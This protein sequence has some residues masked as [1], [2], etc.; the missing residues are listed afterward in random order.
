VKSLPQSTEGA[1]GVTP[2]T[3]LYEVRPRKDK[4]GVDL[5]SDALPFGGLWYGEPDAISNAVDYAKFYSRSHPVVIRVFD[6]AG[7]V[8]KTDQ[9]VGDFQESHHLIE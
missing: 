4:R 1:L 6:E 3:H 7:N 2:A 5:I 8:V 9:H